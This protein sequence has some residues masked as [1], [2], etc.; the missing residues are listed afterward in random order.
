MNFFLVKYLKINIKS[1]MNKMR[2]AEMPDN[3]HVF[4]S[5]KISFEPTFSLSGYECFDF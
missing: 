2:D 4:I 1:I 5:T 3:L